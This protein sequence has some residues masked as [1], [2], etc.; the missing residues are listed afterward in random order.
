[1]AAVAELWIDSLR[2]F[3]L[4][5]PQSSRVNTCPQWTP[6]SSGSL[7][8]CDR[9][10]WRHL[11]LIGARSLLRKQ[12]DLCLPKGLEKSVGLCAFLQ[13]E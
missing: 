4:A 3:S 9:Q 13:A 5:A 11:H 8:T 12:Q 6:G 1:M 7:K 10:D 2:I